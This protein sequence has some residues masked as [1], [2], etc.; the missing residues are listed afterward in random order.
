MPLYCY[1]IHIGICGF[2]DT[3]GC[4]EKSVANGYT[5][6]PESRTWLPT[7][8]G[9]TQHST[10]KLEVDFNST[11]CVDACVQLESPFIAVVCNLI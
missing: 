2:G 10:D 3:I 6:I 11:L 8:Y 1:Y 4:F 9:K 5:A 7:G